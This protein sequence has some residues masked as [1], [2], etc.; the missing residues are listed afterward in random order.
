MM[1]DNLRAN[2]ITVLAASKA[3]DPGTAEHSWLVRDEEST[4]HKRALHYLETTA[5][6]AEALKLTPQQVDEGIAS[7]LALEALEA[8]IARGQ[9]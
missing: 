4:W 3:G 6:R 2:R 5:A 9:P 1:P 8:L 7:R